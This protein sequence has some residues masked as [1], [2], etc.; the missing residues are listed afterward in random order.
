MSVVAAHV[1][2]AFAPGRQNRLH[3][4]ATLPADVDGAADVLVLE[5]GVLD[6]RRITEI[7]N[8]TAMRVLIDQRCPDTLADH[9]APMDFQ[10]RI[11]WSHQQTTNTRRIPL[12]AI[13][14]RLA[15]DRPFL[16][17]QCGL[18][19]CRVPLDRDLA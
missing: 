5:A 7:R 12:P 17:R 16:A 18:Q 9:L 13:G 6:P 15:V 11:A 14:F 1:G 10:T 8:Q 2:V 4:A 19:T 3:G